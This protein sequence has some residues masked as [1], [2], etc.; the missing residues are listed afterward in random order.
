VE[1]DD[2]TLE[3]AP[4]V[5]VPFVVIVIVVVVVFVIAFVSVGCGRG[6]TTE[7]GKVVVG[8]G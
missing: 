7:G 1:V 3:L 6:G 2:F 4:H 5:H 8:A